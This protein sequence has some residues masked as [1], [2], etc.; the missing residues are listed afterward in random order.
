MKNKLLFFLSLFIASIFLSSCA[1]TTKE[2][3]APEDTSSFDYELSPE[4][5]E[6]F[7]I[8]T[9]RIFE[10]A[11]SYNVEVSIDAIEDIEIYDASFSINIYIEYYTDSKRNVY[12][13]SIS[14]EQFNEKIVDQKKLSF[15]GTINN[16]SIYHIEV[17]SAN[18]HINSQTAIKIIEKSYELAPFLSYTDPIIIPNQELN[19]SN[20]TNLLTYLDH[21]ESNFS[22]QMIYTAKINTAV[23]TDVETIE[24]VQKVMAKIDSLDFYYEVIMGNDKFVILNIQEK[25]FLYHIN[26]Y[27]LLNQKFLINPEVIPDISDF[28]MFDLNQ[29]DYNGVTSKLDPSKMLII[30]EDDSYIVE[31][32]LLDILSEEEYLFME[33]IYLAVGASKHVLRNLNITFEFNMT[34][35]GMMIDSKLVIPIDKEELVGVEVNTREV[36]TFDEFDKIDIFDESLFVLTPPDHMIEVLE[37]TDTTNDVESIFGPF[38]HHYYLTHL[39]AGQYLIH[40]RDNSLKFEI[41]D[42][43]MIKQHVKLL[44]PIT[45]EDKYLFL[46]EG[47]YF[48]EVSKHSSQA[49]S[50][51]A[52]RFERLNYET[53][54]NIDEDIFLVPG[55]NQIIIEGS[56]DY[57]RLVYNATKPTLLELSIENNHLTYYYNHPKISGYSSHN[58]TPETNASIEMAAGFHQF[59]FTYPIASEYQFNMVEIDTSLHKSNQ[60]EDMAYMTEEFNQDYVFVSDLLGNAYFKIDVPEREYYSF[61]FERYND[62]PTTSIRILN[63]DMTPFNHQTYGHETQ[64]VILDPGLYVLQIVGDR[65]TG[66]RMHYVKQPIE[67]KYYDIVIDT[68]PTLSPFNPDFPI[69]EVEIIDKNQKAVVSFTLEE[70]SIIYIYGIDYELFTSNDE[71]LMFLSVA[72][73]HIGEYLLL[74]AGDY[75]FNFYTDSIYY[76]TYYVFLAIIEEEIIDDNFHGSII[77][78]IVLGT[79]SFK[80]DNA[81]DKELVKIELFESREY[82][83]RSSEK[84]WIYDENGS[85][86]TNYW[87]GYHLYLEKGI[88]Y[89]EIPSNSSTDD[90]LL[91]IG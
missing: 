54:Y 23:E 91:E 59:M 75:Y 67:D 25:L 68:Y 83:L 66:G 80:K 17:E 86:I 78:E 56:H 19:N 40:D 33:S 16:V 29:I 70:E 72:T 22:N 71:K 87:G 5:F 10:T 76:R 89:I 39:E 20:Y 85:F 2:T 47:D 4:S 51:Y 61:R 13:Y 38:P 62:M 12:E 69:L 79:Y 7:F 60:I 14:T 3:D 1:K 53:I 49:A 28:E 63:P 42:L 90:W 32:K 77:N 55:Q 57:V 18:A 41:Y 84:T 36:Y 35:K 88:Y 64:Y 8:I 37:V 30:K 34:N 6:S 44:N 65:E 31:S 43:D 73:H 15:L 82:S 74:Q 26:P 11:Y 81:Y 58:I 46:D 48:V 21:F 9:P 24:S 52:F 45:Y 27:Q 50:G